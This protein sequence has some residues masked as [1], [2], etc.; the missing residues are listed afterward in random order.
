M[1]VRDLDAV[2][3]SDRGPE[4]ERG[5]GIVGVDVNLE[6]RRVADDEQR[7]AQPLELRLELVP[8]ES[9]PL[10]DEDGAMA[11]AGRLEVDRVVARD[12]ARHLGRR[13]HRL[14]GD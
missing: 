1:H 8:I 14:A 5:T 13:G 6:R 4:R 9:V 12:L 3:R 11:V 7:V 2:D 10:D